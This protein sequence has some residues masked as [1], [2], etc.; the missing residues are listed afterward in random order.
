MYV[1]STSFNTL[2]PVIPEPIT[3][4]LPEIE[5]PLIQT[6]QKEDP[7]MSDEARMALTSYAG[8]ESKLSQIE[9][10]MSVATQSNVELNNSLDA[11]AKATQ[12]VQQQDGLDLYKAYAN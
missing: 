8:Y 11:L 2:Q 1:S 4:E 6:P 12:A 7:I 9:I 5:P 3:P 10:Y